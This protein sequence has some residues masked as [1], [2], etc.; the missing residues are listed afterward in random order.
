[1]KK[2]RRGE[3]PYPLKEIEEILNEEEEKKD[4]YAKFSYGNTAYLDAVLESFVKDCLK[5]N[6]DIYKNL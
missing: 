1:M 3:A 6:F 4:F 5:I 2:I